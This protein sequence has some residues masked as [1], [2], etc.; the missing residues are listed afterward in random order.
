[1]DLQVDARNIESWGFTV[2]HMPDFNMSCILEG[3]GFYIP[4]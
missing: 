4:H 3:L 1:M 2:L